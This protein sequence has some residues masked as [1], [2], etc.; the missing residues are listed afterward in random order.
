MAAGLCNMQSRALVA[1]VS[2]LRW[3]VS[4]ARVHWCMNAAKSNAS[5]DRQEGVGKVKA[6]CRGRAAVHRHQGATFPP[7]FP[8]SLLPSITLPF[9]SLL[10][11]LLLSHSSY[12]FISSHFFISNSG[13]W[14][15]FCATEEA[16]AL[17]RHSGHKEQVTEIKRRNPATHKILA[18][19]RGIPTKLIP[20]EPN[21]SFSPSL[22]LIAPTSSHFFLSQTSSEVLWCLIH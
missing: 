6:A 10:F 11:F 20:N 16:T 9:L 19:P 3:G 15:G 7:S 17:T 21:P 18:Y 22:L 2:G 5:L 1:K 12:L 4:A 13:L 8:P 14:L